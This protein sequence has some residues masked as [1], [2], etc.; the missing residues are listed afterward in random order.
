MIKE[1]KEILD[2]WVQWDLRVKIYQ[3]MLSKD[4]KE[5]KDRKDR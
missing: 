4:L 3:V 2:L 1:I 5:I